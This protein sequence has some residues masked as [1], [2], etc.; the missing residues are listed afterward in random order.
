VLEDTSKKTAFMAWD[1][2]VFGFVALSAGTGCADYYS[3]NPYD[4]GFSGC[5]RDKLTAKSLSGHSRKQ[6]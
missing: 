2:E 5:G 4:A 1:A 3:R 6:P